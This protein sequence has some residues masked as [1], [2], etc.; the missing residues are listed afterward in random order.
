MVQVLAGGGSVVGGMPSGA[1]R[2]EEGKGW[3]SAT[4]DLGVYFLFG[5]VNPSASQ[6]LLGQ[7]SDCES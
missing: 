6:V 4:V 5:G 3:V 2:I 1:L 7:P